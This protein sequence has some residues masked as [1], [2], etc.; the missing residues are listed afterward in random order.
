MKA[1]CDGCVTPGIM[2]IDE[3]KHEKGLHM[4]V[5]NYR[6]LEI[7]Q[8]GVRFTLAVYEITG[9]FPKHEQFG[10]AGQLQ[11]AAVS[12]PSN[13]AEGHVQASDAV[14]AR[15]LQIAIGSAAEVDTQLLIAQQLGYLDLESMKELREQTQILIRRMNTL[16]KTVNQTK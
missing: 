3:Y 13:I 8:D 16:H 15:H 6:D 11:R 4:S 14:F 12:I 10:L 5:R 1:G 7:W 2:C 9:T